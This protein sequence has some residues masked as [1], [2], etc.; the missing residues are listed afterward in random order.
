[1]GID[2]ERG[3]PV[4]VARMTSLSIRKVQELAAAGKIP[5]AV[6]DDGTWTFSIASVRDWIR[7]EERKVKAAAKASPKPTPKPLSIEM[8]TSEQI[9]ANAIP[10][11]DAK[12]GIYFLIKAGVIVYVGKSVHVPSR[13]MSHLKDKSFDAWFWTP[14]KKNH[15]DRLERT[16]IEALTPVLNKDALT[17]RKLRKSSGGLFR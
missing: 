3:R 4:D 11:H 10:V 7:A 13:V 15:L 16:Y 5:S 1:M 8:L 12:A 14:C 9:L 2:V 6:K 17:L